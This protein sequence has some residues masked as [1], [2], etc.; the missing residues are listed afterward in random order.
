MFFRAEDTKLLVYQTCQIFGQKLIWVFNLPYTQVSHSWHPFHQW[1]QGLVKNDI[2]HILSFWPKK[3][4]KKFYKY[5]HHNFQKILS[6][7]GTWISQISFKMTE[8]QSMWLEEESK[9]SKSLNQSFLKCK[10]I[11]EISVPRMLRIFCK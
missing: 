9:V 5:S 3:L 8:L 10:G 6:I 2:F 4:Q 7:L 11:W 1:F